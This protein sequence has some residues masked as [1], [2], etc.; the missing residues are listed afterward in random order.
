MVFGFDL[1][2]ACALFSFGVLGDE[3]FSEQSPSN[4]CQTTLLFFIVA[5]VFF[6]PPPKKVMAKIEELHALVCGL[7]H[8]YFP[9]FEVLNLCFVPTKQPH[10]QS[11]DACVE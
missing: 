8:E 1:R 4:L 3:I 11:H 2:C 6:F 10:S 9:Y 5:S 7:F